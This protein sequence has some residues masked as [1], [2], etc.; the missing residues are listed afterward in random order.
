M[1]LL[2][3]LLDCPD[4]DKFNTNVVELAVS[5]TQ[6][7]VRILTFKEGHTFFDLMTLGCFVFFAICELAVHYYF[8]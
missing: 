1:V 7:T 5:L 4:C 6:D 2:H 8:Y 3:D